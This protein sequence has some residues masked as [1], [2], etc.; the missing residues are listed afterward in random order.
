MEL[1]AIADVNL[2]PSAWIK[3][4]IRYNFNGFYIIIII[5]F[6]SDNKAPKHKQETY[7]QTNRQYK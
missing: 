6:K 1:I 4:T 2:S 5:L 3:N 7:R